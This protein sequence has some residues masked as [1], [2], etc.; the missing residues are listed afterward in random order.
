VSEGQEG[1]FL[2]AKLPEG[3]GNTEP[4]IDWILHET[5]V[6]LTP[7]FIFGSGGEGYV[8][9]SLCASEGRFEQAIE[10]IREWNV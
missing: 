1:L 6:F 2:W 4:F 8:R 10:R 3:V 9:I 7:G 5:G